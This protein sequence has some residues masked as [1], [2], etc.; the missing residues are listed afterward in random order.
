MTKTMTIRRMGGSLGGTFP[1]EMTDLLHLHEGDQLHIVETEN[2]V[3]LT[4]YDPEFENAMEAFDVI[5]KKYRNAFR[6]LA[7]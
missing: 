3:L 1:K 7:K 5:R 2:G 4:P 6:E